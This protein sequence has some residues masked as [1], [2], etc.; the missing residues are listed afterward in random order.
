ML[1][2]LHLNVPFHLV[3]HG[4]LPL[5]EMIIE[6]YIHVLPL[7]DQWQVLRSFLL[8]ILT[9]IPFVQLLFSS[10]A[11]IQ[12]AKPLPLIHGHLEDPIGASISS[13]MI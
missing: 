3:D 12:I 1:L 11:R 6:V 9:Q 2:H 13:P 8:H 4:H 10:A 7:A 5:S